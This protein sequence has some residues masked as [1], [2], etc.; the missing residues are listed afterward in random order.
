MASG[1]C[2]E[3]FQIL[4][5]TDWQKLWRVSLYVAVNKGF[6]W[7]YWFILSVCTWA[8]D[9]KGVRAAGI[10]LLSA[11]NSGEVEPSEFYTSD[12]RLIPPRGEACV[13][14]DSKGLRQ[15]STV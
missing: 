1:S 15:A 3:I 6:A 14:Y 8:D 5:S 11:Y 10:R 4:I 2:S 13:D 12:C 9:H 7:A